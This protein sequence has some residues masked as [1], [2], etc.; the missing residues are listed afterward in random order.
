MR[1]G[2][3]VPVYGLLSR[4]GI[5]FFLAAG[6]S[7]PFLSARALAADGL[8]LGAPG[9]ARSMAHS[10]AVPALLSHHLAN[11]FTA[12]EPL[13]FRFRTAAKTSFQW[14][15]SNWRGRLLARGVLAA[16]SWTLALPPLPLGYYQLRL[17][18]FGSNRWSS[19]VPLARV[20]TP[21]SRRLNPDSPF[22]VESAQSLLTTHDFQG[23]KLQPPH[24]D[25]ICSELEHLA[26]VPMVRDLMWWGWGRSTNPKPG[27]YAWGR[28]GRTIHQLSRRGIQVLDGLDTRHPP[29]WVKGWGH[30]LMALY[31]Y[32]RA[33]AKHFA[34]RVTAWEVG[35]EEDL[36]IAAGHCST[37]TAA[38]VQKAAYLGLKAG[39]RRALVLNGPIALVYPHRAIL[40]LM[41]RNGMGD[42]FNIFDFH[43]YVPVT[44]GQDVATARTLLAHYGFSKPIWVSEVGLPTMGRSRPLQPGGHPE[45]NAAQA[46]W[47]A[48]AVV[49]DEVSLR[50]LGVARVFF[51]VFP[52]FS[53]SNGQKVWGLLRWNWTVKPGY[54]ALAN[55]TMQLGNRHYLGPLALGTGVHA[56]LF[57]SRRVG[58]ASLTSGGGGS[59][60]DGGQTLVVWAAK[61]QSVILPV[62]SKRVDS[63]QRVNLV[64][65]PSCLSPGPDQ[66]YHLTVGRA[67]LFINGPMGLRPSAAPPSAPAIIAR[68]SA[69]NLAIVLRIKLGRTFTSR[70][71]YA[72]LP[73]NRGHA[74][75]EAYNFGSKP[76]RGALYDS[77][78]G[79]S[80]RGLPR[81]ITVP[82]MG[83]F[84]LPVQVQI[85]PAGRQMIRQHP[86]R[87]MALKL[88]GRFA[89]CSVDPVVIPIRH[90]FARLLSF[91]KRRS[92]NV[93]NPKRWN[94]NA[95]GKMTITADKRQH[96]VRF[97][98]AFP[99]HAGGW[100]YPN[101]SLR[102]PAEGLA[103]SVGVSFQAKR[104]PLAAGQAPP[105]TTSNLLM[106]VNAKGQRRGF[107][108]PLASHWRTVYV[109]WGH[110]NPA[111]VV[112][113]RIGCNPREGH[114]TYWVRDFNVYYQRENR[115]K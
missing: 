83:V 114:F 32:T 105:A 40:N 62:R 54:V 108:Y 44:Y 3:H 41:L 48:E 20:A 9:A 18:P 64:G 49:Q 12:S 78:V 70:G 66:R 50:A 88:A 5:A 31:R 79:W 74:L 72:T 4:F 73:G 36:P 28:Y 59:P 10:G 110:F 25:L 26:G 103:G 86:F 35:N 112:A 21:A 115:A 85:A 92:M 67:P 34:G 24:A 106:A 90:P 82:A 69:K 94:A 47:Q 43:D 111:T 104:Q 71:N 6:L 8:A 98:V 101:F 109:A 45:D 46:R 39:D 80:I 93:V 23:N 99:P 14:R 27:V 7:P 52:P 60:A 33:A 77:S 100:V 30:D 1:L 81:R 65:T 61:K 113:L 2:L 11:V 56:Y 97:Q 63:L 16:G 68:H 19:F 89:G 84:K 53:G 58:T 37:W 102:V 38:A 51:F 17:R 87:K 13:A 55:L 76:V 107:P 42:Y 75:V 57:Q 96:A 95:S 29:A 22:C 15:V 91:F